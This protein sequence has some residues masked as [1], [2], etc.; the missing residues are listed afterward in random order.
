MTGRPASPESPGLAGAPGPACPVCG[1][2]FPAGTVICVDCGVNLRTG[3]PL[4]TDEELRAE[5]EAAY[6]KHLRFL[7]GLAPGL[8]RRHTLIWAAVV[9]VPGC[10]LYLSAVAGSLY[11][12]F[13][14]M[15][16]TIPLII[17][18]HAVGFLLSGEV[19]LLPFAIMEFDWAQWLL[20]ILLLL[21]PLTWLLLPL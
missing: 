17:Y 12:P 18:A 2:S 13:A 1:R 9:G 3:E 21:L 11:S 10:L 7:A 15:L 4:K 20:F 6:P 16:V 19:T 5:Q 8:F 14:L